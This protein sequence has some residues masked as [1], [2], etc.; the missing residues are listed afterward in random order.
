MDMD[1][2]ENQMIFRPL[3]AEQIAI[4]E[5]KMNMT[6]DDIIK[7]SRKTAGS[8]PRKPRPYLNRRKNVPTVAGNFSNVLSLRESKPSMKHNTRQK[9]PGATLR[10][11]TSVWSRLKV[12]KPSVRQGLP[13]QRYVNLQDNQ[14]I[15][16]AI[17]TNVQ[18]ATT[19]TR[20]LIRNK[21]PN[22]GNSR[23][24]ITPVQKRRFAEKKKEMK[25]QKQ[26]YSAQKFGFCAY[27]KKK[28]VPHPTES[29]QY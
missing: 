15:V 2:S 20:P 17:A 14:Y 3:S 1:L 27:A 9:F 25:W 11:S 5:K 22:L 24:G 10:N 4:N 6:L 23:A 13:T 8:D 29:Y 19:H 18:P 16:R 28:V 26:G 12:S 7:I 21:M